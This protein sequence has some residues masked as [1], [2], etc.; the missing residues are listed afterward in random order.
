MSAEALSNLRAAVALLLLGVSLPSLAQ[1]YA[2]ALRVLRGEADAASRRL[3]AA[4]VGA[5]AIARLLAPKQIVTMYIG[6]LLTEQAIEL[7]TASHYGLGSLALYHA[8]FAVLP[9]DHATLLWTNAVVGVLTLPLS[10]A[11]A[12]RYLRS[13]RAG[14]I[15]A[16]LVALAPLFVKNDASDANHVP[17]LWWL[18]GGLVLWEE[19][20]D[21]GARPA[22]AAAVPLLA[23]AAIARPEMPVLLPVL[24]AL[25]TAG[26]APPWKRLR[27]PAVA[28]AVAVGALLVAPHAAHVLGAAA[29]LEQ[30]DSLPGAFGAWRVLRASVSLDTVLTPS[31]YPLALVPLAVVGAVEP[32]VLKLHVGARRS[33]LAL[34]AAAAVALALYGVDLC[35]ANMARVHVPG[36]LLVTMLAAAGLSL[37]W[38]RLRRWPGRAALVLAVVAAA[39]PTARTLWA[40]TNEQAEED[41]IREAL[42]RLP[43]A[44]YTLVRMDR[45]DRDRASP[46]SDFTHHHFPDYLVRP[47]TGPGRVSSI[48]DFIDQPELDRPA[49]FYWGMRCY[50]EFR[51]EDAPRPR[52]EALQP[53]CARMRDA[54]ALTPVL[55][56]TV[57]NRGD[58]W[59][60]YYGDAPT[61]RLGLYR[62]DK[63]GR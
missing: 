40:P 46:G 6:Y 33:R 20:L 15:F 28:A 62:I 3:L 36:A 24:L 11:F 18:F 41:F 57:P 2:R 38:G 51:A 39:V 8:L 7:S 59:L 25:L 61:L 29:A 4:S 19:H 30:R 21:T 47:P 14:A 22:L 37:L 17:C 13:P 1:A 45:A 52:G 16:A 63:R 23:L 34:L 58:V 55:E 54:F 42:A 35:R 56:R 49:F 44:P 53:A 5:A 10:A 27:D 60:E 31:L 12:A 26:M 48:R 9:H 50:A 43:D 32:F